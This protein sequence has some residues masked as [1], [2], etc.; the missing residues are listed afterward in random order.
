MAEQQE[1]KITRDE[2]IPYIKWQ[3]IELA[4]EINN[5]QKKYGSR[6]NTKNKFEIMR[7]KFGDPRR[8]AE[9]FADEWFLIL[10]KKSSLPASVRYPVRDICQAAMNQCYHDKLVAIYKKQQEEKEKEG[11]L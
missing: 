4:E 10:Q 11:E 5:A 9:K 1:L 6:Y 7:Y 2:L 3:G 8:S